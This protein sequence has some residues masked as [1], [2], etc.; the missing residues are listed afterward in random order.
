MTHLCIWKSHFLSFFFSRK[1]KSFRSYGTHFT[2]VCCNKCL[3]LALECL[4]LGQRVSTYCIWRS[5][6]RVQCHV[7]TSSLCVRS[8]LTNSGSLPDPPAARSRCAFPAPTM[9]P[10]WET[11]AELWWKD[12]KMTGFLCASP[13]LLQ[14]LPLPQLLKTL[15]VGCLSGKTVRRGCL[16]GPFLC[17]LHLVCWPCP[18]WWWTPHSAYG[19]GQEKYSG[20]EYSRC[21]KLDLWLDWEK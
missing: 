18:N 5:A 8:Q 13:L 11:L 19:L 9:C 3:S 4:L 16:L 21:L 14:H 7:S 17:L 2:W 12:H 6:R 20:W 15:K 10:Q 1:E